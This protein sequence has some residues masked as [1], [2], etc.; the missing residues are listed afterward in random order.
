MPG[1]IPAFGKLHHV[2]G[3]RTGANAHNINDRMPVTEE[4]SNLL[5]IQFKQQRNFVVVSVRLSLDIRHIDRAARN[6]VQYAHQR[7][8]RVAIV[9][10]ES[11]HVVLRSAGLAGCPAGV[12]ARRSFLFKHHL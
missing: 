2:L 11:V 6:R 8:L 10:M 9:D 12:L 4:L 1:S 7:A 3:R 5:G